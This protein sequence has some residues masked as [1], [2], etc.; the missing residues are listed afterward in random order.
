MSRA[1]PNYPPHQSADFAAP[2]APP[3]SDKQSEPKSGAQK[4]I[5]QTGSPDQAKQAVDAAAREQASPPI[6]KED[7]A[8][9]WGFASFLEMFEASKPLGPAEENEKWCVTALRGGKWLLWNDADMNSARE[10]DSLEEAKLYARQ[11]SR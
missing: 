6:T 2:A 3:R 8:R 4:L 1:K 10:Y 7:F 9:R 5:E 11:S